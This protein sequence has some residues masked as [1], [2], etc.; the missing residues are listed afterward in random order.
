MKGDEKLVGALALLL[1]DAYTDGS[2]RERH[3]DEPCD[4]HRDA[5]RGFVDL[6]VVASYNEG[7]KDARADTLEEVRAAFAREGYPMVGTKIAGFFR[8]RVGRIL[9]QLSH[10][11]ES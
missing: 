1:C 8:N 10:G 3:Y 4:F 5:A 9:D 2:R 6:H 7:K 11:G